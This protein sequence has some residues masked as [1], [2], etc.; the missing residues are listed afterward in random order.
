MRIEGDVMAIEES[1]E[2]SHITCAWCDPLSSSSS[3]TCAVLHRVYDYLLHE[4]V[5]VEAP[6]WYNF[7]K[8]N[9]I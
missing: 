6:V 2:F 3:E 1:D 7:V 9:K 8:E 5:L 4:S